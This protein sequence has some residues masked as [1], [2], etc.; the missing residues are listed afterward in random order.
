MLQ[1]L[2]ILLFILL[3]FLVMIFYLWSENLWVSLLLLVLSDIISLKF[4]PLFLKPKLKSS[5][6]LFLKY[7][8]YI[9]LPILSAVFCRV[10]LFEVFVVPSSSM[11]KTIS[12]N[13]II[14]TNKLAYGPAISNKASDI[15]FAS[16]FIRETANNKKQTKYKRLSGF[17]NIKRHDIIVYSRD[18]ENHT[19]YVKRIIGMPGDT[20]EIIDS[21]VFINNVKLRELKNYVFE[22]HEMK[23]S[24]NNNSFYLSNSEYSTLKN[25]N[26]LKR[27]IHKSKKHVDMIF[28]K[29]QV[30]DWTRDNY[31]Y[32]VIPAK[33]GTVDI[34]TNS[35]FLYKSIIELEL[36]AIPR[37][38]KKRDLF[39]IQGNQFSSYS[40][41]NDY[42]F[43]IGDNRHN[44]NDSRHIGFISEDNII[45]RVDYIF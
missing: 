25:K 4:I 16:L 21:N 17:S 29:E 8:C 15:P 5:T 13:D 36:E 7:S 1:F 26:T 45:G 35:Y 34:N 18:N 33:E 3:L 20:L 11:K 44:S 19:Y 42:Y 2:R 39:S 10:F 12:I 41:K 28:P 37:F 14:L 40:F 22:Y 30:F 9:L 27:N 23:D 38:D 24:L 6:Y 31:G 43:V 32:V